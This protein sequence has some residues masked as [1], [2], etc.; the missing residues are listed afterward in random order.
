MSKGKLLEIVIFDNIKIDCIVHD[1]FIT[2]TEIIENIKDE[3]IE[4]F[5]TKENI[6]KRLYYV[7]I[8][9]PSKNEPFT[10]VFFANSDS[11]TYYYGTKGNQYRIHGINKEEALIRKKNSYNLLEE[12]NIIKKT[13]KELGLTYAQLGE[14]IGYGEGALKVA[15][16]NNKVSE[17]MKKAIELY[18]KTIELEEKLANSEKIKETLKEWLK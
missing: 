10:A 4:I 12:P 13:C 11:K 17:P 18:L 3:L 8:L 7:E 14:Q 6:A 15:V 1:E 9:E 16:S 5:A 2:E